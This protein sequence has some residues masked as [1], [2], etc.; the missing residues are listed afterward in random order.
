MRFIRTNRN[1]KGK[2][3]MKVLVVGSGGRKHTIVWKLAQSERVSK[4]YCI[5]GNGVTKRMGR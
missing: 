1:S 3:G 4:I 2:L 5:P